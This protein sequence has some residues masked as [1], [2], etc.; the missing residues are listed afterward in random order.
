M[1]KKASK[2]DKLVQ[3]WVIRGAFGLGGIIV[4]AVILLLVWN[5]PFIKKIFSSP[6]D[7]VA[8]VGSTYLTVDDY[9]NLK[10][11]LVSPYEDPRTINPKER[12]IDP[13]IEQEV[14]YQEALHV[15]LEDNDTVKMAMDQLTFMFELQQRDL[16]VQAWL[17]KEMLN[18]AVN[19]DEVRAYYDTHKEDFTHEV[20]LTQIILSDP[21]TAANVY[22]QLQS[23]G[24]F[25]E[26]ARQYTLDSLRGQPTGYLPYLLVP[27][28]DEVFALER[29]QYTAP[30]DLGQGLT[31]F[32][33]LED[34]RKVRADVPY[35]E[36]EFYIYNLLMQER[37]QTVILQKVDSIKQNAQEKGLI[38]VRMENIPN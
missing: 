25:R 20:K 29:G 2:S 12:V 27:A 17:E 35:Q 4:G 37:S 15:G 22:A 8:R 26:L 3:T 23:G 10:G 7:F 38:E 19:P 13:W 30:I 28:A 32:F 14:L 21:G 16:L 33:K 11:L 31:A 24:N 18:V 1:A 6:K 9:Q 36:F 34:K 5:P